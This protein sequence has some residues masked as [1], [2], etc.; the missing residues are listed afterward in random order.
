MYFMMKV[1]RF[2]A[3]VLQYLSSYYFNLE[4][5]LLYWNENEEAI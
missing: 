3:T 1:A 2:Y 5:H 4:R